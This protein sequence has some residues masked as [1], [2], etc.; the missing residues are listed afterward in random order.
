MIQNVTV[1]AMAK[2]LWD[3]THIFNPGLFPSQAVAKQQQQ[4]QQQNREVWVEFSLV[5]VFF[6][7]VFIA[8]L[9]K[10]P[11]AEMKTHRHWNSM[12]FPSLRF[13]NCSEHN[14]G[15]DIFRNNRGHIGRRKSRKQSML[16]WLTHGHT[17]LR[18]SAGNLHYILLP[19]THWPKWRTQPHGHW[20]GRGGLCLQRG[21]AIFKRAH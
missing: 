1:P 15:K 6:V 19:K 3:W 11:R 9:K 16:G 4:Q 10:T 20:W 8:F 21:K 7:I 17:R 12:Y 13:H 14:P 5:A 2:I 18:M